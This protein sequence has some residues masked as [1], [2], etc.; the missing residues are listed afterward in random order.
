MKIKA[1]EVGRAEKSK[2]ANPFRLMLPLLTTL[3]LLGGCATGGKKYPT[4]S[5]E[6]TPSVSTP[7]DSAGQKGITEQ[8]P[9]LPEV[10]PLGQKTYTPKTVSTTFPLPGTSYQVPTEP[11]ITEVRLTVGDKTY[12]LKGK[13]DQLIIEQDTLFG[14]K[15]GKRVF[16]MELKGETP[17]IT[18]IKSETFTVEVSGEVNLSLS[19]VTRIEHEY[20]RIKVYAH[21]TDNNGKTNEVIVLQVEVMGEGEVII[22]RRMEAPRE[23]NS[24]FFIMEK[25]LRPFYKG[26][27]WV[28]FDPKQPNFRITISS[29]EVPGALK[30]GVM[31]GDIFVPHQSEVQLTTPLAI[32]PTAGLIFLVGMDNPWQLYFRKLFT[33]SPG[34]LSIF[35]APDPFQLES[36]ANRYKAIRG[37]IPDPNAGMSFDA[38]A[39][40]E[41]VQPWFS[42]GLGIGAYGI[43]HGDTM[44][45]LVRPNVTT[46]I[47]GR[48][49]DI[50]GGIGL[51][52]DY[53]IGKGAIVPLTQDTVTIYDYVMP[54]LDIG[55]RV[56]F[57]EEHG[58][59]VV[60]GITT[61]DLLCYPIGSE[62]Y[63]LN[64]TAIG[65]QPYT[66]KPP[67]AADIA[68][69]FTYPKR[70]EIWAYSTL[71]FEREPFFT[72]DPWREGEQKLILTG[73]SRPV[74]VGVAFLS[75]HPNIIRG[76]VIVEGEY[77]VLTRLW[78]AGIGISADIG[79]FG[80]G[81]V[82]G[83]APEYSKG[84][85]GISIPKK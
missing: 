30:P 59:R 68:I 18:I 55:G 40:T 37:V 58:P 27:G 31:Q 44:G 65:R 11:S 49:K 13:A 81:G 3:A 70:L 82:G 46:G 53:G 69:L 77:D 21:E 67:V 4:Y 41:I 78:Y 7:V 29:S 8:T 54:S 56:I 61:R 50:G 64:K 84:R 71:L 60:V 36:Y 1:N 74:G 14:I 26:K 16:K 20:G 10:E 75:P 72:L 66:E 47:Y 9:K 79:G 12:K 33:D 57:G 85:V 62:Y 39:S 45:I 5:P 34:L 32:P 48:G 51:R 22:K 25:R 43:A 15:D 76:S 83:R 19:G 52:F 24:G 42:G 73:K 38:G 28:V 6:P 35:P 2:G 17:K 23:I 80:L 63:Y